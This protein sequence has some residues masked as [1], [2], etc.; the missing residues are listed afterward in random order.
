MDKTNESQQRSPETIVK[1][2]NRYKKYLIT[3]VSHFL[4][5]GCWQY[6]NDG[7]LKSHQAIID[8]VFDG[9]LI[10]DEEITSLSDKQLKELGITEC[11]DKDDPYTWVFPLELLPIMKHQFDDGNDYYDPSGE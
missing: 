10:T 7:L 5:Y 8:H 1:L 4:V 6:S 2:I 9:R 3:D 11:N